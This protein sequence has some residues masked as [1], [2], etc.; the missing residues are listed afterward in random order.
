MTGFIVDTM[1]EVSAIPTGLVLVVSCMTNITR[2]GGKSTVGGSFIP[3]N[4]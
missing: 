1:A 2:E 3:E 4:Q